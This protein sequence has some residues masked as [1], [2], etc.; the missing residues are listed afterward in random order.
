M[1][2]IY[3]KN[4]KILNFKPTYFHYIG[5]MKKVLNKCQIYMEMNGLDSIETNRD[6]VKQFSYAAINMEILD[7]FKSK[8]REDDFKRIEIWNSFIG[9][10][11]PRELMEIFPVDK[12]YDGEKYQEK[13]YFYTM[14][15]IKEHGID[16]PIGRDN[17]FAFVMDYQNIKVTEYAVKL[18]GI[19]SDLHEK[20]TGKEMFEDFFGIKPH[21]VTS[22]GSI[23]N[24]KG[25]YVGKIERKYEKPNLY[26]KIGDSN[27]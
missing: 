5:L 11:T 6:L 2:N 17:V 22:D 1:Y 12:T 20:E 18:M 27:E 21:I 24:P 23:F 8:N 7:S 3:S 26:M 19:V 16:T 13:D 25:E 15:M 10:I 14:E 9:L 4:K